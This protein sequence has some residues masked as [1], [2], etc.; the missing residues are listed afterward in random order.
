MAKCEV[1]TLQF[2]VR[3]R[4]KYDKHL[5]FQK[6]YDCF[7][8]KTL[9][10]VKHHYSFRNIYHGKHNSRT[11]SR[12]G[13]YR[14]VNIGIIFSGF[15]VS[16][17]E[18]VMGDVDKDSK[19]KKEFHKLV[20]N[21][22][23][24]PQIFE[25]RWHDLIGHGFNTQVSVNHSD[26]TFECSCGHFN[27]HGYLCRHVFCVFRI[28]GIDSIPQK[29][30]SSRFRKN[31]LP[32]HL[33][34]KR[35]RYGPCIEETEVIASEIMSTVEASINLIRNDTEKLSDLLEKVKGLKIDIESDVPVPSGPQNKDALYEDLLGVT[36][37]SKVIIRNPRKCRPKGSKR[38]KS[39]VEKGKAQKRARTNRKVPFRQRQCSNCGQLGHNKATCTNAKVTKLA[40]ESDSEDQE[41]EED[42]QYIDEDQEDESGDHED[43][44]Q[45]TEDDE[46]DQSESSSADE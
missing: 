23:I 7:V 34:D 24:S 41:D 22:Y 12:H 9:N 46:D 45:D 6:I 36:A 44:D 10:Q 43:N 20:W 16:T 26:G 25:E 21:M 8:E 1:W 4:F 17:S 14:F 37:P 39:A 32:A 33:R 15:R 28:H 31:A 38:I 18:L 42:E 5:G 3:H 30:I 19:F 11:R 2:R 29:Y 27:R 35:H 40:V 13:F